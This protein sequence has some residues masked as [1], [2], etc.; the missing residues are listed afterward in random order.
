MMSNA[1]RGHGNYFDIIAYFLFLFAYG[2]SHG[3]QLFACYCL[4]QDAT[5]RMS[6]ISIYVLWT[7]TDLP[8]GNLTQ[9]VHETGELPTTEPSTCR[10]HSLS[11]YDWIFSKILFIKMKFKR[12]RVYL[13]A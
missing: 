11:I 2:D 5:T 12:K 8:T 9:A 10:Y 1:R 4:F 6:A 13:P 7:C 3:S